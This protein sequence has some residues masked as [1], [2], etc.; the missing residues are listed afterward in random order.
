VLPVSEP[1]K[2]AGKQHAASAASL[3]G[4]AAD[5]RCMLPPAGSEHVRKVR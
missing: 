2:P 5:R 1:F 3:I 4:M